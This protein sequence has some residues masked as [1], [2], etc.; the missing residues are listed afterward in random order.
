MCVSTHRLASAAAQSVLD[1]GG[2]VFDAVTTGAFVL[3]MVEPR[4]N[5]PGGDLIAVFATAAGR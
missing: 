4:L 3:H 5:G 1:Q 2:N